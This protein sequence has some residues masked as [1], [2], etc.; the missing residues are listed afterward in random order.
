MNLPIYTVD[1]FTSEPFKGNPAAVCILDDEIDESLMKSIAFEMNLSETAFVKRTGDSYSLRWFTPSVEVDL[2]GHA[3][4][5]SSHILWQT[6]RRQ[7][8]EPIR[9]ITKSGELIA[10]KKG[11][12]IQLD[13][14]VIEQNGIIPPPELEKALGAK[15]VYCGMTQWNYLIEFENED[16]IKNMQPDFALLQSLPSWGTIVTAEGSSN[17]FDF[18]SRFFAPEK[19]IPEDPV[20]G[21]AHC[22]LGPYWM[23]KLGKNTFNAY[24]ASERGGVVGVRVENGRVYLTGEAVTVIEGSISITNL[25]A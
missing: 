22:A 21:S 6:D 4:L 23:K 12:V 15:P 13:F 3:T 18:V 5:A 17:G 20:T 1:A 2:C 7:L 14:P 24:Q 19:G 16:I 8:N 11:N 10:A 25:K 9:F